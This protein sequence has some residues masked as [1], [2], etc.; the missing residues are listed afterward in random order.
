MTA[1]Q[2]HMQINK[3]SSRHW[4]TSSLIAVFAH[5]LIVAKSWHDGSHATASAQPATVSA[6]GAQVLASYSRSSHHAKPI[7]PGR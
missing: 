7:V 3:G 4:R 1:R 6:R 2:P 5:A